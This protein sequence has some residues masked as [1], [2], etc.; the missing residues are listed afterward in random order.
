MSVLRSQAGEIFGIL[1]ANGSGKSMMVECLQGLRGFDAAVALC[2]HIALIA[3]NGPAG[4]DETLEQLFA[5]LVGWRG[6]R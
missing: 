4:S 2:P 6:S 3:G 5:S 1:G